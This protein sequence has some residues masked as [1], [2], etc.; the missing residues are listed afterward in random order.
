MAQIEPIEISGFENKGV[1]LKMYGQHPFCENKT[2]KA[3]II[4]VFGNVLFTR[5][6][7][8]GTTEEVAKQLGLTLKTNNMAQHVDE[9][10]KLNMEIFTISQE[11]QILDN[12]S[13]IEVLRLL[14]D[15]LDVEVIKIQFTED[16]DI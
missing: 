8:Y 10:G 11:Y 6:L 15:W 2:L 14:K 3:E 5:I 9:D 7:V 12:Q 16:E 4:D 13:K 1:F